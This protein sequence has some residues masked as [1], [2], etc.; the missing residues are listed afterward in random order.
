MT[1]RQYLDWLAAEL[2]LP[3]ELRTAEVK[4]LLEKKPGK[5]DRRLRP[6]NREADDSLHALLASHAN[7]LAH[8]ATSPRVKK[9]RRLILLSNRARL[10]TLYA[11]AVRT[12]EVGALTSVQVQKGRVSKLKVREEG[13][14]AHGVPQRAGPTPY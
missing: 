9:Q 12:S 13:D 10:W 6:D 14:K 8:P 4:R 7:G 11:T 2:E 1:A 3:A 5:R